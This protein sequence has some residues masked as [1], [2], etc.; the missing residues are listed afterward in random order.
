MESIISIDVVKENY[1]SQSM[2][3]AEVNLRILALNELLLKTN[4]ES[5]T[6]HV[7][8][9]SF[10][11]PKLYARVVDRLYELLLKSEYKVILSC[12]IDLSGR[13]SHA[14]ITVSGWSS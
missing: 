13:P 8:E 7:Y 6:L 9:R 1:V 12:G 10:K 4:E 11:N 14:K 3:D 5:I 2:V